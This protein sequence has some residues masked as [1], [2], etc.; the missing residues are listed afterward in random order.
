MTTY[1][2]TIS[3]LPLQS[4]ERKA[5]TAAIVSRSADLKMDDPGRVRVPDNLLAHAG[6]TGKLVF[7]G[8]MDSFQVWNPDAY[9]VFEAEMAELAADPGVINALA[10][11]YD[12]AIAAGGVAGLTLVREDEA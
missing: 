9:A 11:P 5:L 4:R 3:R 1:M 12:A 8:A 7:V 6:I 10:A 2:Q